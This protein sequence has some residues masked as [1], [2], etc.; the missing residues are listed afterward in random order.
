MSAPFLLVAIVLFL[1]SSIARVNT[2]I[3]V[4]DKRIIH[5]VGWFAHRSEEMNITKIETVE[6]RQ[7]V[8]GGIFGYGTVLIKGTGGGWEPLQR[9]ALPLELR[10]AII[11]G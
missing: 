7:G 1:R 4:T 3:V 5:K 6:V 8:M 11:V 10:N 2:E 9:V